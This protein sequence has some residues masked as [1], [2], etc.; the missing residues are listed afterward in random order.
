MRLSF[1]TVI[2]GQGRVRGAVMSIQGGYDSMRTTVSVANLLNA[3]H[4]SSGK[5]FGVISPA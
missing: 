4:D 1:L 3:A 5:D 2:V